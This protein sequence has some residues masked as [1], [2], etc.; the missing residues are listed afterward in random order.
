MQHR[1]NAGK[2]DDLF[3]QRLLSME[4]GD[5]M[6]QVIMDHALDIGFLPQ[7]LEKQKSSKQQ[8][9]KMA[10]AYARRSSQKTSVGEVSGFKR[11]PRG[12]P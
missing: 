5:Q 7:W 6:R 2:I 3:F 11:P 1:A 4:D 12:G 10:E 9:K 8:D